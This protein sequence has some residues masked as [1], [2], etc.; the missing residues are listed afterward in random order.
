LRVKWPTDICLGGQKIGG[1]LVEGKS[2]TVVIGI[3]VN[4]SNEHPTVCLNSALSPQDP[5]TSGTLVARCLSEIEGLLDSVEGGF[6]SGVLKE[7]TDNWIHSV[8]IV[9]VEV[10]GGRFLECRI[11]GVDEFGFSKVEDVKSGEV[12]SVR[13]DG[14]SFDITN[15]LIAIKT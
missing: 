5:L 13:C 3:G 2:A 9:R 10:N 11:Q 6:L 7:Y 1:V 14:N 4:L 12:L 8:D 15:K